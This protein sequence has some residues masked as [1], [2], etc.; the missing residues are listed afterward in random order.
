M[1]HISSLDEF[2]LTSLEESDVSSL[3]DGEESWEPLN[4]VFRKVIE[5]NS[6][7]MF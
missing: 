6:D 3:V 1:D 5:K 4:E 7:D 2:I